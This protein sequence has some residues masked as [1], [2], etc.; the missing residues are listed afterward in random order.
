MDVWRHLI[1]GNVFWCVGCFSSE[2]VILNAFMRSSVIFCISGHVS[3]YLV[4]A[5]RSN[6]SKLKRPQ[7]NIYI[8]IHI[9]YI[10]GK[11]L[12]Y[13]LRGELFASKIWLCLGNVIVPRKL[14]I[15]LDNI[16][17]SFG[18]IN[19]PRE[20]SIWFEI[21]FFVWKYYCFKGK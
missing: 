20:L 18:N 21:R 16:I 14:D 3:K 15:C 19:F 2:T 9:Y 13:L 12:A 7:N 11:K 4:Y 1:F 6:K 5:K 8:Y 10:I 17:F